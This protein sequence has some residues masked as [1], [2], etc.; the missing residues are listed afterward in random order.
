MRRTLW[1]LLFTALA[2]TSC[3]AYRDDRTSF[4]WR[5]ENFQR[6]LGDEKTVSAFKAGRTTDVAAFIEKRKI[7][8]P[9]FAKAYQEVLENEGIKLFTA[10]QTADYFYT[11]IHLKIGK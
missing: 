7:A 2:L 11:A 3:M 6:I 1:T 4:R 9:A 5:S 8:D 10:Q